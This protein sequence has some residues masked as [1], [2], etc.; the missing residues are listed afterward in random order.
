MLSLSLRQGGSTIF[1]GPPRWAVVDGPDLTPTQAAARLAG[2]RVLALVHGYRVS[3]PTDAYLRVWSHVAGLYDECVMIHWPGS[4]WMLG[5]WLARRRAAKAGRLLAGALG[6]LEPASLDVEGHSLGCMVALEAGNAGLRCRNLILAAAAVDN[7][8]IEA[9]ERY[10]PAVHRAA[11]VLVAFSRHDGVL[12]GAYRAGLWDNALGLTGPQD[13][14]RCCLNISS[15]DCSRTV[16]G[17]SEYKRDPA[18]LAAWRRL[19]E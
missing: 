8:S 3:E 14:G 5:F 12:A 18:F 11:H 19:L 17:H 4:D 1:F 13:R 9:G 2:K 10:E 16:F 6:P 7:E 15:V